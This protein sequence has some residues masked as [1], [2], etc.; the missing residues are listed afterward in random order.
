MHSNRSPHFPAVR[1]GASWGS[2]CSVAEVRPRRCRP[3]ILV[4]AAAGSGA[5]IPP[6]PTEATRPHTPSPAMQEPQAQP[7][8]TPSAETRKA[9][10]PSHNAFL[11]L[12]GS[13]VRRARGDGLYHQPPSARE[14]PPCGWR[15]QC[16]VIGRGAGLQGGRGSSAPLLLCAPSSFRGEGGVKCGRASPPRAGR[17]GSALSCAR[18]PKDLR[19]R[20]LGRTDRAHIS[21]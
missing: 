8:T 9:A 13:T 12:G 21:S 5:R 14:T 17:A 15:E 11:P 6:Q 1:F 16:A 3:R 4:R 2:A 10:Q 7:G 19:P 20:V 18:S